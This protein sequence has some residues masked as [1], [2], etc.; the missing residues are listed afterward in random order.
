MTANLLAH[1]DIFA[2]RDRAQRCLQPDADALRLSRPRSATFWE[3]PEIYFAMSPFMH[4]HQI[5]EPILLTHGIADNNSGTFPIQSRRLYHALKG[6]GA[7]ARL[8]MFPHESH[9][10]RARESVLHTLWE[11]NEW[12]ER[13]VKNAA[14][15]ESVTEM[16]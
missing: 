16:N 10:F 5:N 1:S 14:P 7:T 3:A 12:L 15:R 4:A 8:V 13:H 2:R 11:M 9:G 6:H